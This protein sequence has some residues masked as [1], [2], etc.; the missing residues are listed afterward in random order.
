M[1]SL[2][3]VTRS[4]RVASL[5]LP[6]GRFTRIWGRVR[7]ANA[8]LRIGIVACAT[9][10][11]WLLAGGWTPPFSHRAGDLP[12]RNISARVAFGV[13]D[14]VGTE[15]LRKS[16][17]SEVAC[18]YTHD[19]GQLRELR[20][21]LKG[22]VFEMLGAESPDKIDPTIW[23]EFEPPANPDP[24]ATAVPFDRAAVLGVLRDALKDDADLTQFSRAIQ[25]AFQQI[26][27]TGLIERLTH[28]P[29]DG[30]QTWVKIHSV[31]NPDLV[32]RVDVKQ[33][34]IAEVLVDLKPRLTEELQQAKLPAA[35]AEA[36]AQLVMNWLENRK[37]PTTLKFDAESTQ[38]DYQEILA[39]VHV[40]HKYAIGDTLIPGGQRI[41]PEK[42]DILRRE[43]REIQASMSTV[44]KILYSGAFLGLYAAAFLF[45]GVYVLSH[46]PAIIADLRRLLTLLLVVLLTM[47]LGRLC[48]GELWQAEVIP[49]VLFGMTVTIAF[50]RELALLLS[51]VLALL[52]CLAF[53][54]GV[55]EFILMVATSSSAILFLN[56]VR[57]RTKLIY[58]GVGAGAVA[59]MT[60]IGI[61]ILIGEP[62]GSCSSSGRVVGDGWT[63][64][65]SSFLAH[66]LTGAMWHGFCAVLASL[67]MTGLL[68]FIER[69]FDVQTDIS[70]LELGDAAH[71]LLQE[72]A[73]RAP[74]TYNHSIN[75]A[76]L[77]EAA[78]ESIGANGLL[79]RVG[80]YFH[81][82]GKVFKPGY[83]VENQGRD[84][85]RHESLQPAMSTLVIIA[86]VKDGADLAR[87][88]HLP[89]PIIDFIEQHH[90]TTLVEYFFQQA[91]KQSEN[92]PD[93]ETVEE[94]AFR[95]PG[96]K[97]QTREAAVLMLAD[98]AESASRT[99]VDPTPARI[100]SLVES[101][102]MKRLLDG[103]FDDCRLTLQELRRIR[104]SL[105]KLLTAVYHA[106]VKYPDQQTA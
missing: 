42:L 80:A 75:V 100:D 63:N 33:V 65:E 29:E 93:G 8:L 92:D 26:E 18:T 23:A 90:G 32:E 3:R 66:L 56:R 58:V 27:E 21:A 86:H 49:M 19:D 59:I 37:L 105:V 20:S 62:I 99:L 98:A 78:A 5:A 39:N 51:A 6:P 53:G 68:P 95:Y 74:G 40:E 4:D 9:L 48:T 103:Q 41:T 15:E 104:E 96:P 67:I 11:L 72:L 12:K 47:G 24:A 17:R 71:T 97:P 89:Q 45:C 13:P 87:Q 83:F 22:R 61:G 64:Q 57:S 1:S 54:M 35:N 81:D 50:S 52:Q 2:Q 106:R 55:P 44:D 34:R 60:T 30:S 16:K 94:S 10:G 31:G 69:L 102:T 43:H 38:R 77:A 73:R 82:I 46:H 84:A 25:R 88:H 76:S 91:T 70:L 36:L 85:N 7:R 101:I 28:T 79:A 14:P